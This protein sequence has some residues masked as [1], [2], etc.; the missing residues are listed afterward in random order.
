MQSSQVILKSVPSFKF[1]LKPKHAFN[2]FFSCLL[3]LN[4][5]IAQNPKLNPQGKVLSDAT[6]IKEV[7]PTTTRRDWIEIYPNENFQGQAARYAQNIPNY[8]YPAS[9]NKRSVSIKIAP[10]YIAYISFNEDNATE[11]IFIGEHAT[12]GSSQPLNIKSI[13]IIEGTAAYVN[14][15]GISTEIHNNDCKRVFGSVKARMYERL[16]S[17][18]LIPCPLIERNGIPFPLDN[19]RRN[20]VYDTI[21][22]FS[23]SNSFPGHS[24]YGGTSQNYVFQSLG[25]RRRLELRETYRLENG[26]AAGFAYLVNPQALRENRIVLDLITDLGSHHKSNDLALDYSSNIKIQR[27]EVSR[28]DYQAMASVVSFGPFLG[29][30]NPNDNHGA[31]SGVR[32]SLSKPFIVHINKERTP[33]PLT[34]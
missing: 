9:F 7:L 27:P 26:R 28:I 6:R 31:A 22:L 17:G 1:N 23:R 2:V 32:F 18:A 33:R 14:F 30:G 34:R 8:S 13:R 3:L 5:A 11:G 16:P 20:P 21:T 12:F 25:V 19:S 4:T 29:F 15:S 10:G 24:I